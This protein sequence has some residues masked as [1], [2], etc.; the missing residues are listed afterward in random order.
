MRDMLAIPKHNSII[1]YGSNPPYHPVKDIFWILNQPTISM[2]IYVSSINDTS[3]HQLM[4]FS[5]LAGRLTTADS[6]TSCSRVANGDDKTLM[7]LNVAGLEAALARTRQYCN[8]LSC[9]IQ[10]T[11]Q[12][13]NSDLEID[14]LLSLANSIVTDLQGIIVG[15]VK[16][17]FQWGRCIY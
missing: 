17:V 10:N 9:D 14:Q 1:L 4:S 11:V 15:T 3:C 8:E 16:P 13:C 2:N 7:N 12:E 5:S 6:L